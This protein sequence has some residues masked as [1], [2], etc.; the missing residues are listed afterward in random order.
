MERTLASQVLGSH[1][2]PVTEWRNLGTFAAVYSQGEQRFD[3]P[4]PA[5]VR[6]LK[7]RRDAQRDA[8]WR[9]GG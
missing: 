2:Y 1:V 8:R 5:W 9:G 7:A 4:E 6:F 3:L